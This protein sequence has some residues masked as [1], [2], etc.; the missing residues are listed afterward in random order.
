M[1]ESLTGLLDR[2]LVTH[3]PVGDEGEMENLAR[4]LLAPVCDEVF[5]DPTGNVIGKIAGRRC[6][7][8]LLLMAHKD[9]ISTIVRNIEADG[10]V[11]L[12]SLG[13][14]IP[15]VYGEGPFDLLGDE[16]VTGI[17]SVG[18]RHS[19][20][21]SGTVNEAR[22]KALTWEMCYIDCLMTRDQLTARGVRIGSRGCVA[23]CRKTPL[24]IGDVVG[25]YSI[26]DKAGVAILVEVARQLR[27]L[28]QKP[29][30]DLYLAVTG[31]EETGCVGGAYAGRTLPASTQIAVEIAPVA[32]EYPI[33]MSAAPVLLYKDAT[34]Q[35]H[36]GLSDRLAGICD[37]A[38]GGHQRM[39]VRSF[40]SD[41]SAVA[42]Y[43]F[44]GRAACIAFPTQNTHGYELAH[45]GAMENCVL[46]LVQYATEG[47]AVA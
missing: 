40:G 41:A 9:E 28:G 1:R 24:Y 20:H 45:L 2:L 4:D 43:G 29:A 46:A 33:E 6:D 44:A 7:D 21:L 31:S 27:G 23:R 34:L 39:L 36:K 26:D 11:W 17:L 12:D 47:D 5:T 35:Y 16:V 10:K 14:C 3:S 18:S 42:K 13:G 25:G 15:W 22:T 30:V 8:A 19:S 37:A 38:C 32:P